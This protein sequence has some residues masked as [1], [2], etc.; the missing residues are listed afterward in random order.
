MKDKLAWQPRFNVGVDF[1]DRDH[2]QLFSIMNKL[3]TLSQNDTK[4]EWVGVEG[5]KYFKNHVEEHFAREEQYMDS[6]FSECALAG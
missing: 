2:K 5:I 3:L 1:I 4:N 6:I